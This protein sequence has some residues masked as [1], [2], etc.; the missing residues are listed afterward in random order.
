MAK[1]GKFK[2]ITSSLSVVAISILTG[3]PI[4]AQGFYPP[5]YLFQPQ[6][7]SNYPYRDRETN[8]LNALERESNFANLVSELEEAGLTETLQTEQLTVLAPTDTAFNALPDEVFDQ[9]TEPDNLERVLK[10]HLVAGQVSQEA[11]DR[12]EIQT[13]E[14]SIVTITNDNNSVSLNNAEANQPPIKATNGVIIEIDEVLL[15]PDF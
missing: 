4:F 15:P 11:I 6:A 1:P 13:L 9:L 12:G 8:L 2:K 3:V 5:L 14:G 10:Y 7:G